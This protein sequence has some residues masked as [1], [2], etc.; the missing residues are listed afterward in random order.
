M[1]KRFQRNGAPA[2]PRKD[3]RRGSPTDK[4]AC[5]ETKRRPVTRSTEKSERYSGRQQ[6]I[7]QSS[8]FLN[9]QTRVGGTY[10]FRLPAGERGLYLCNSTEVSDVAQLALSLF[11]APDRHLPLVRHGRHIPCDSWS[12][13]PGQRS[14]SRSGSRASLSFSSGITIAEISEKRRKGNWRKWP[15]RSNETVSKKGSALAS[16][17]REPIGVCVWGGG[18]AIVVRDWLGQTNRAQR[19]R[20]II[21]RLFL[22]AGNVAH[23]ILDICNETL[24][25][26][27]KA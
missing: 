13:T 14:N 16:Q 20:G 25:L 19:W 26:L 21:S 6:A 22:T 2:A 17:T 24:K 1:G 23:F 3:S 15:M 18:G 11:P 7:L 10:P 12:L 5:S 8:G 4:E 9:L 27:L